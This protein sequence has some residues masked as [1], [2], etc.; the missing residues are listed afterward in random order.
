MYLKYGNFQH[1]L[2]DAAVIIGSDVVRNAQGVA[3]KEVKRWD[4]AGELYGTPSELDT[5]IPLLEAAYASDG[6]DARI[7]HDN[8]S[9]SAHALINSQ[10]MERVKVVQ[11]PNF[12]KGDGA[13][14]ANCRSYRIALQAEFPITI[15]P[16]TGG[17]IGS[18]EI[19]EIIGDGGPQV[20]VTEYL[21]GP[22]QPQQVRQFTKV[23]VTQSGT[24]TGYG[25]FPTPSPPLYPDALQ[26]NRKRLS[27]K[28]PAKRVGFVDAKNQIF[29]ISWSYYFELTSAVNGAAFR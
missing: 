17:K 19:L 16:G 20:I 5:L 22:A 2:N 10:T 3:E 6:Y 13:E 23:Q 7:L 12:P 21:N 26:R 11:R 4:I 24:A 29:E 18:Q 8:G 15:S 14:Y 9:P 27:Y 28:P 25:G 1:A